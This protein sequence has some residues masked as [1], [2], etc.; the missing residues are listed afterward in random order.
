MPIRAS[1]RGLG[2]PD[3]ILRFAVNDLRERV[4]DAWHYYAIRNELL[5]TIANPAP[6]RNPL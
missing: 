3:L 1:L 6:V 2:H 5:R 4:I